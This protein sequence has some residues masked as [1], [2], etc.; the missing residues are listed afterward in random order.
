MYYEEN[1]TK[2]KV[3]IMENEIMTINV[4]IDI[5]TRIWGGFNGNALF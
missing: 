1:L 2:D 3:L 5:P 4:Y